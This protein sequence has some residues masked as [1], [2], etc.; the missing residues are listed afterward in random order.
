MS[1]LAA[2]IKQAMAEREVTV[3]A[4]AAELGISPRLLQKWRAGDTQPR[5]DNLARLGFALGRDVAWFYTD[6]SLERA[7]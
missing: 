3:D 6:H 1:L 2:N 7:A 4:L 5:H